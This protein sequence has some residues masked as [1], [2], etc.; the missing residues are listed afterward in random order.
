M[1]RVALSVAALCVQGCTADLQGGQTEGLLAAKSKV[2]AGASTELALTTGQAVTAEDVRLESGPKLV[3]ATTYRAWI[4]RDHWHAYQLVVARGHVIPVG[5]FESADLHTLVTVMPAPSVDAVALTAYSE[6][7]ALLA[8]PRG[9]VRYLIPAREAQAGR[10]AKL[11]AILPA[12][13]PRDTV[14][15]LPDGGK[16]VRLTLL[17]QETRSYTQHWIATAYAFTF[18]GQGRLQ[19]WARREG[20]PIPNA[21]L[22]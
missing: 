3:G 5:G 4:P 13:W 11:Q 12:D 1:L 16:R 2:A 20:E 18:D 8:D 22:P 17:S 15:Q 14:M 10:R 9:A 6:K 7:L 19:A 21:K